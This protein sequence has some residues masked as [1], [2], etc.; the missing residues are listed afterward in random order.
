MSKLIAVEGPDRFGKETQTKMLVDAINNGELSNFS[1]AVSAEIPTKDNFTYKVIYWMLRNGLADRFPNVFQ[2]LQFMNKFLFQLFSLP[3]LMKS[4]DCV[5]LD[6]WSLSGLVYGE[7]TGVLTSLNELLFDTLKKPDLTLIMHGKPFYRNDKADT[8][9]ANNDL[10]KY[11]QVLYLIQGHV[12]ENA[13]MVSNQTTKK[14]IHK[15]IKAIVQRWPTLQ[16]I[17]K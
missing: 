6:R 2:L 15:K 13:I 3:T 7:A 16:R 9:E 4:Y 14:K 8:Y 11:V 5:V 12:C 17:T 10:Q 1:N